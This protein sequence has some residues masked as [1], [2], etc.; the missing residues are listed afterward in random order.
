MKKVDLKSSIVLVGSLLC[1]FFVVL[2][3][4]IFSNSQKNI[5]KVETIAIRNGNN[6]E[7][8][9]LN[10]ETS[11]AFVSEFNAIQ[12]CI[13]GINLWR[14]GYDYKI[15]LNEELTKDITV[16]GDNTIS[17]GIFDYKTDENVIEVIEKYIE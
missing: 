16:R 5:E 7:L 2:G 9:E 13:S 1:A 10:E 17:A 4:M 6:G 3:I 8:I 14:S 12:K 11:N 15:L